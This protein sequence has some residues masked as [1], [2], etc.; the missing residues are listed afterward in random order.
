MQNAKNYKF[1]KFMKSVIASI[2][3][4]ITLPY[5]L[6]ILSMAILIKGGSEF[7]RELFNSLVPPQKLVILEL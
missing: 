7:L 3:A 4:L 2:F 6:V 5:F 1:F